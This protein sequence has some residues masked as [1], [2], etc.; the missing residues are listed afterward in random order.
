[1]TVVELFTPKQFETCPVCETF[2]GIN[3]REHSELTILDN[4]KF[5]RGEMESGVYIGPC[6]ARWA[7]RWR[8]TAIGVH[9]WKIW[10]ESRKDLEDSL[11][12]I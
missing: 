3:H 12:S 5:E 4:L 6:K 11:N 8:A 1:M 2:T 10:Q 9:P 7:H